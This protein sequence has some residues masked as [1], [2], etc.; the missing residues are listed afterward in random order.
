MK[1]YFSPTYS[2][3][4]P[5]FPVFQPLP[6][7]IRV[8]FLNKSSYFFPKKPIT[9]IFAPPQLK[10]KNMYP[11]K[12]TQKISDFIKEMYLLKAFNGIFTQ[13]CSYT[14]LKMTTYMKT[15]F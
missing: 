11:C 13:D 9:H 15:T 10:M 3:N 14:N 1:L 8:F 4:F 12:I 5:F 7:F 2:G 6:P